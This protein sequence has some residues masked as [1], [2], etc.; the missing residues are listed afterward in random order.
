MRLSKN[1]TLAELTYS[2]TASRMGIPNNPN[3]KEIQ[4]L[5]DVAVNILQ[6]IR[7]HYGIPFSPTSGYRGWLLNSFVGGVWN[8]QHRLG[9]AVDIKIPGVSSYA[10]AVWIRDNLDFDQLILEDYI[11]G[12]SWSGWVHVSYTTSRRNRKQALTKKLGS[13]R[14]LN[15]LV[16]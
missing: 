8:S 11:L 2:A 13:R 5:K 4:K 7:E 12:E 14:Y 9:E 15:G 1:F 3:A 6:P 10:L 16:K